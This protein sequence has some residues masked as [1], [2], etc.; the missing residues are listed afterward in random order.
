VNENR[1]VLNF[2]GERR[3]MASWLAAPAPIGGL[4]FVSPEAS[5]VAAFLAKNPQAMLDDLMGFLEV[6]DQKAGAGQAEFESATGVNLRADLAGPLSGEVVLAFDGSAVPLPEWVAAVEVYDAGR[7]QAAIEKLVAATMQKKTGDKVPLRIEQ[8]AVSGQAY[9]ALRGLPVEAHYTYTGGYLLAGSN[10]QVIARALQNKA[11]GY[12]IARSAQF[13]SALPRDR[14]VNFSA[15][16]YQNIAGKLA[17]VAG[18]LSPELRQALG[19]LAKDA[20]PTLILAYG[21]PD[22]IVLASHGAFFGGDLQNMLGMPFALPG[23][24]PGNDGQRH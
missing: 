3:G 15:M 22:R 2:A 9:Y 24:L 16:F 17:G 10:R 18:T 6:T 13:V 4:D 21:E 14:H 12:S 1:A 23:L 11:N 20:K 5:A 8:S 7:L 19:D